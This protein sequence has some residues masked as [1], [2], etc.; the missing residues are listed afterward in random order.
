[1]IIVAIKDV[2]HETINFQMT[3]SLLQLARDFNLRVN[4]GTE[5]GTFKWSN[6]KGDIMVKTVGVVN[7][8]EGTIE[9]VESEYITVGKIIEEYQKIKEQQNA[10]Q[11]G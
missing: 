8:H 6:L 2:S 5:S 11:N 3:E 4:D 10:K 9:K 7:Q 1:M